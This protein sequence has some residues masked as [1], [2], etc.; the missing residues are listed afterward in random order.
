MRQIEREGPPALNVHIIADNYSA[1]KHTKVQ[2]WLN[3]L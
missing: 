1:H 3:L 2:A